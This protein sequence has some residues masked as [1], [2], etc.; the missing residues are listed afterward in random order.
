MNL[1]AMETWKPLH[2]S[3]ILMK[4]FTAIFLM[5]KPLLKKQPTGQ[6]YQDQHWQDGLGFWHEMDDGLDA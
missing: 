1:V 2:L 6:V 3:K 4:L 5:C